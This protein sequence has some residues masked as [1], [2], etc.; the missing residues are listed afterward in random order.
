VKNAKM[1]QEFDIPAAFLYPLIKNVTCGHRPLRNII[2]KIINIIISF[3]R[4]SGHFIDSL[5]KEHCFISNA[6]FV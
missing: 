1:P 3:R 2:Y 6:L 4:G 5:K